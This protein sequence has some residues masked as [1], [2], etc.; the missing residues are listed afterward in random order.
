MDEAKTYFFKKSAYSLN[1]TISNILSAQILR[2]LRSTEIVLARS[3]SCSHCD[4]GGA[5]VTSMTEEIEI[6]DFYG[7]IHIPTLSGIYIPTLSG[8]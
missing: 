3:C 4:Y 5:A 2:R 8:I 6:T 1:I 7:D